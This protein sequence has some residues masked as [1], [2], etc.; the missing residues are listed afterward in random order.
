MDL[1]GLV[2]V[3]KNH[4]CLSNCDCICSQKRANMARVPRPSPRMHV[5]VSGR[6]SNE[7][8]VVRSKIRHAKDHQQ[9]R[10]QQRSQASWSRSEFQDF[11][12]QFNMKNRRG[13][14]RCW[15]EW[16]HKKSYGKYPTY[17]RSCPMPKIPSTYYG[18]E[19]GS[20]TKKVC[21]N[22]TCRWYV[23][24]DN[25]TYLQSQ[26]KP[27]M[28]MALPYSRSS[29]SSGSTTQNVSDCV[30]IIL[31]ETGAQTTK[32]TREV[33]SESQCENNDPDDDIIDL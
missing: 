26:W 29:S 1:F 15:A 13:M 4:I 22:S 7:S 17:R 8:S 24:Q 16:Q 23:G 19:S 27:G 14:Q 21:I 9:S 12:N 28:P 5:G 25:A 30:I 6:M 10:A 31:D 2:I 11:S 3:C 20:Q 18:K 32:S 33:N